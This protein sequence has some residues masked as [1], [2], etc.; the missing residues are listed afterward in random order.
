[1]RP[2][3]RQLA[4]LIAALLA[5]TLLGG[6]APVRADEVATAQARVDK[7]QGL[8][9]R[10]AVKLTAGT[11]AY[12]RDQA[13]LRAAG[14]EL[15]R[16]QRRIAAVRAE[17]AAGATRL[18]ALARQMYMRPGS[19]AVHIAVTKG[20]EAV[21]DALQMSDAVSH[22]AGDQTQVIRRAVAARVRLQTEQQRIARLTAEARA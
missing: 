1:M 11:R 17:A 19:A 18:D 14:R 13:A 8:V 21:L 5:T 2:V 10:T 7:L 16:S 22:V 20:P 15:A 12:E 9:Q 6:A 4:L 3:V